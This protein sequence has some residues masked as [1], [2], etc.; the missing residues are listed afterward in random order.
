MINCDQSLMVYKIVVICSLGTI[1]ICG[2]K[3]LLD[4]ILCMICGFNVKPKM[5]GTWATG[6]EVMFF[7]SMMSC[8]DI[9]DWLVNVSLIGHWW[10]HNAICRYDIDVNGMFSIVRQAKYWYDARCISV[11]KQVIV[12]PWNCSFSSYGVVMLKRLNYV[13]KLVSEEIRMVNIRW[14]NLQEVGW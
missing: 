10:C 9:F 7:I 12:D 6:G 13:D 1:T 14:D 11:Y 3:S 8:L 2:E 4:G 5:I